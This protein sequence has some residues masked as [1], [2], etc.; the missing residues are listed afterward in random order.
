M[1]NTQSNK[2]STHTVMTVIGIGVH[3]MLRCAPIHSK[4]PARIQPTIPM[5]WLYIIRGNS[6]T[7]TF[8]N[9]TFIFVWLHST[10]ASHANHCTSICMEYTG[11]VK[12]SSIFFCSYGFGKHCK[13]DNLFYEKYNTFIQKLPKNRENSIF[14]SDIFHRYNKLI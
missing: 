5:L 9:V 2:S 1:I 13:C 7:D 6:P 3:F 12:E 4:L 8:A 10:V 11:I 14:Y